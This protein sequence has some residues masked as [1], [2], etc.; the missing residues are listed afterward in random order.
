MRAKQFAAALAGALLI[1]AVPAYAA[2]PEAA[3]TE[4]QQPSGKDGGDQS[5]QS[6]SEDGWQFG[7]GHKHHHGNPPSAANIEEHRLAKL[8]YMANYFGI[9]TEGKT[10]EQLKTELQAAKVKDKAKWEAFK[11][12]H[13]AKRLEHL[14]RIA[15]EHGI[16]TEGKTS[17]QLLDELRKLRR[18]EEKKQ[19]ESNAAKESKT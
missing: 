13:R 6:R 10:V 2:Q 14:R 15:G 7:Q 9:S 11:A 19:T 4:K 3:Q 18:A 16:A 1:I 17:D 5:Q 12:E 8:R